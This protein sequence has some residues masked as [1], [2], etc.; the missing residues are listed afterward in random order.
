MDIVSA[1]RELALDVMNGG[2]IYNSTRLMGA[3]VPSDMTSSPR[4]YDDVIIEEFW[5]D[6][7]IVAHYLRYI[8]DDKIVIEL[9]YNKEGFGAVIDVF[10]FKKYLVDFNGNVKE[11]T[12]TA[13]S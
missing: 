2:K 8:K 13:S 5:K 1:I 6:D 12:S 11:A 3:L 7:F 9:F 10:P 4:E